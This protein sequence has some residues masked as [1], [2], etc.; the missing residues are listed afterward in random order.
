MLPKGAVNFSWVRIVSL[1]TATTRTATSSKEPQLVAAIEALE[2]DHVEEGAKRATSGMGPF[3]GRQPRLKGVSFGCSSL[4]AWS[5]RTSFCGTPV[6][7]LQPV[8]TFWNGDFAFILKLSTWLARW[9]MKVTCIEILSSSTFFGEGVAV[10]VGV[11]VPPVPPPQLLK[12]PGPALG[13]TRTFSGPFSADQPRLNG[14]LDGD[15]TPPP[16]ST[17]KMASFLS[18]PYSTHHTAINFSKSIP[19]LIFMRAWVS[20]RSAPTAQICTST[21]SA[22]PAT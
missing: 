16:S 4:P 1:S 20:F 5:K 3:S 11:L 18:M 7:S 15:S 19:G 12:V 13:T 10:A 8:M 9:S 21:L 6:C 17:S 22:S 2:L 14:V